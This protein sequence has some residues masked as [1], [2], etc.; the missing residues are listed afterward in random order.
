M[1][2]FMLFGPYG[3][4]AF[5]FDIVSALTMDTKSLDDNSRS[6]KTMNSK[7]MKHAQKEENTYLR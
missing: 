4:C 5:N 2:F 7:S 1:M 6:S 3:V